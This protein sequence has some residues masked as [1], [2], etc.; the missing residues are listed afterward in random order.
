MNS[1]Q[2]DVKQFMV[3]AGQTTYNRPTIPTPEARVLHGRLILEETLETLEAMGLK[4]VYNDD[5]SIT[6]VV[7]VGEARVE[8]DKVWDG[9]VDTSYVVNGAANGWGLCMQLGHDECQSSNLSKFIDGHRR[10]DGKW[11]KGPS[12][13]PADF[14]ELLDEI[15]IKENSQFKF[16]FNESIAFS[17]SP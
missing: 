10:D 7:D 15:A 1:I 9:L 12:Y 14:Q 11:V 13:R 3:A 17:V 5:L 6:D 8:L 16:D 2:E 4:M